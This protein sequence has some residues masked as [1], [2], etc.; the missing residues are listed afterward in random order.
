MLK[1]LI[2]MVAIAVTIGVPTALTQKVLIGESRDSD[3]TDTDC[4]FQS[5]HDNT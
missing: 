1:S 4:L 5:L 2:L 3:S